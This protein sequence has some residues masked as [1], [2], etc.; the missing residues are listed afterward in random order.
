MI[1][2]LCKVVEQ[3]KINLVYIYI[4]EGFMF[5]SEEGDKSFWVLIIV[6]N[7]NEEEC[8]VYVFVLVQVG[9]VVEM[10]DFIFIQE[11]LYFMLLDYKYKIGI[12]WFFDVVGDSMEFMLFEGDK[13]ICSYLEFIFW[14]FGVKD[15]Y[16][17]VVVIWGDVVVKWVFNY[18]KEK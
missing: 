4:G 1:E 7:F 18:L 17:Y 16:V 10:I 6:I 2:L 11:L 8:I 12:Y 9:Y 5:M 13:V 3:Y 15:S 14:E